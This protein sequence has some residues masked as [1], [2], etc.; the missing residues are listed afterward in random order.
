MYASL[1]LS[2]SLS[3]SFPFFCVACWACHLVLNLLL[4]LLL[5]L[6]SSSYLQQ[7][8]QQTQHP[9]LSCLLAERQSIKWLFLLLHEDGLFCGVVFV[10]QRMHRGS[11]CKH[12]RVQEPSYR[13]GRCSFGSCAKCDK[14]NPYNISKITSVE[15]ILQPY[16]SPSF[17]ASHNSIENT[18]SEQANNV[19][20]KVLVNKK[21]Y[22]HVVDIM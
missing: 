1:S 12:P 4:L 9:Q 17:L 11:I 10:M 18:L 2:L 14:L 7:Q 5:L 19:E 15:T 3:L 13:C 21:T 8:T 20:S 22:K 16:S 6:S